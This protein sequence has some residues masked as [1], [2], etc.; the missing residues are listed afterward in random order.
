MNNLYGDLDKLNNQL[1]ILRKC[2]A[3]LGASGCTFELLLALNKDLY[4]L[5]ERSQNRPNYG[6]FKIIEHY[7]MGVIKIHR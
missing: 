1:F 7:P 5:Y 2:L 4:T 3:E 6:G